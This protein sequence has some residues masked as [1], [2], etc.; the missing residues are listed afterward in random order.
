M[1]SLTKIL[2]TLFF[3]VSCLVFPA[4]AQYIYDPLH[5]PEDFECEG[6]VSAKECESDKVYEAWANEYGDRYDKW[7]FSLAYNPNT[8]FGLYKIPQE[9]EVSNSTEL[10]YRSKNLIDARYTISL[11]RYSGWTFVIQMYCTAPR[12][13][14]NAEDVW[15]ENE[16]WRE[17][18]AP[19]LRM[20]SIKPYSPE[21][22]Y[23]VDTEILSTPISLPTNMSEM[24]LELDTILDW[25]ETNLWY[26][27]L[28]LD[29][30]LNFPNQ[31]K[32]SW[33]EKYSQ[34]LK[35]DIPKERLPLHVTADGDKIILRA[36]GV[37]NPELNVLSSNQHIIF[38]QNNRGRG[39][40]WAKKMYKLVEPCLRPSKATPPWQKVLDAEKKKQVLKQ[41]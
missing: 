37:G 24:A 16:N 23:D 38:V 12:V 9:N 39:Y 28:A 1:P 19:I 32:F 31:V 10:Y 34:W 5:L 2:C 20:V 26:C 18:C 14:K 36:K 17:S 25:R 6:D 22:S 35:G 11:R 8:Y 30:L 21:N 29:H 3:Y 27:K 13:L 4:H 15:I 41:D 7:F 40:D 33:H